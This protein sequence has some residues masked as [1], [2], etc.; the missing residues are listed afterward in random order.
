MGQY[1]IQYLLPIFV[2]IDI[3]AE[4][5][6]E[7]L[8]LAK[9]TTEFSLFQDP[10]RVVDCGVKRVVGVL[11]QTDV[12]MPPIPELADFESDWDDELVSIRNNDVK[13]T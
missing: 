12:P 3:E 5:M 6:E 2:D 1:T 4:S 10:K 8:E 11:E 7:A 13:D 9:K